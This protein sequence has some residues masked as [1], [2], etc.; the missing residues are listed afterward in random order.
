[1]PNARS[2]GGPCELV[3]RLRVH[4]VILAFREAGTDMRNAGEM[5]DRIDAGEQRRPVD[6][7]GEVA[8]AGDLDAR[9]KVQGT[10]VAYGGA[11]RVAGARERCGEGTSDRP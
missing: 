9:G 7:P 5:Y 10:S 1:M 4:P 8:E 2:R 11:H 6:R 3:G